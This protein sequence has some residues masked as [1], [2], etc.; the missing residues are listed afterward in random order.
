MTVVTTQEVVVGRQPIFDS[1]RQIHGFELLF[2]ASRND[3]A[4]GS[5]NGDSASA[6]VILNAMV[7]I[8]LD[9]LITTGERLFVNYTEQ[10]LMMDPIFPPDHFVL[11]VLETVALTEPV[12][13]RLT[14]L[15]RAGYRLALDDFIWSDDSKP[16]LSIVDYVKLDVRQLDEA[17]LRKTVKSLSKFPVQII[18]EKVETEKEID[19]CRSLGISLFQGYFLRR[20]DVICKQTVRPGRVRALQILAECES[21]NLDLRHLAAQINL[22]VAMT[23]GLLRLSNCV[24]A[25]GTG[26]VDTVLQA[27]MRLGID[28]VKRWAA[29]TALAVEPG[30]PMGYLQIALQRAHMCEILASDLEVSRSQSAFLVGL[31]SVLDSVVNMPM[32]QLVEQLPLAPD[33]RLALVDRSGELGRVLDVACAWEKGEPENVGKFDIPIPTIRNAWVK[34]LSRTQNTYRKALNFLHG[35]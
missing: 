33:I 6:T 23:Y 10:L 27:I 5:V 1:K 17:A 7:E 30:C 16:A 25:G 21:R 15:R 28:Q 3:T 32:R 31:L 24:F 20:P 14:D 11:E 2:R 4:F 9:N 26:R 19:L 29:L 34:S 22:D 18:A 35:S 13:Q 8:G 12:V